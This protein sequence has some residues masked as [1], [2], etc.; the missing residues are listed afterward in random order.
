MQIIE[1]NPLASSGQ[2][3]GTCAWPKLVHAEIVAESQSP[4][5]A[6]SVMLKLLAALICKYPLV[7]INYPQFLPPIR[8]PIQYLI[9]A[10]CLA[11]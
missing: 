6:V 2:P 5:K 4:Y 8:I 3:S 10:I 11:I 1:K 7:L 9:I